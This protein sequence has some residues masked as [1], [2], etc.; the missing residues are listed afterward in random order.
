MRFQMNAGLSKSIHKATQV[1]SAAWGNHGNRIDASFF[2]SA[3]T[4]CL[5]ITREDGAHIAQLIMEAT[6]TA[7]S[8]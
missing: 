6:R 5:P 7:K 8:P 4:C 1:A 2:T 3:D